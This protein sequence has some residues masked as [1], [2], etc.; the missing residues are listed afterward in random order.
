MWSTSELTT[1]WKKKVIKLPQTSYNYSVVFLGYFQGNAIVLVDDMEF[2]RCNL[3]KLIH[4]PFE[5]RGPRVMFTVITQKM[6]LKLIETLEI[7]K[8]LAGFILQT[9]Y[10]IGS[11]LGDHLSI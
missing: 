11:I 1:Y 5:G 6:G 10:P 7:L 9:N 3:C 8:V 2:M 4:F